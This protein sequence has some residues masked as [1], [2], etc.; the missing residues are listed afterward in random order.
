MFKFGSTSKNDAGAI[1]VVFSSVFLPFALGLSF[2]SAVGDRL[3]FWGSFGEHHV[4]WEL[5]PDSCP[6]SGSVEAC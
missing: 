1:L 4:A 3:G 6:I 2:L 5:S